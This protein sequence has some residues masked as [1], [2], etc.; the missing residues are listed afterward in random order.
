M[1]TD[2]GGC[3][4]PAGRDDPSGQLRFFEDRGII[5]R[6]RIKVYTSG[7]RSGAE[8]RLPRSDDNM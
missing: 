5:P 3:D 4:A 6:Q 7:T 8:L 2:V 1:N